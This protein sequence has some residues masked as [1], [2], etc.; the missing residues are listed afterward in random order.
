MITVINGDYSDISVIVHNLCNPHLR[1]WSLGFA[2][3]SGGNVGIGFLGKK[4]GGGLAPALV[5]AAIQAYIS[6]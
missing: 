3:C 1:I 4:K 2:I 5:P 6:G